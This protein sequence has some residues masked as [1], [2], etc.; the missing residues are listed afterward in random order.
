[1]ITAVKEFIVVLRQSLKDFSNDNGAEWAAAIAYYTLLSIFPLLLASISIGA[2]FVSPEWAYAQASQYLSELFPAGRG[3]L[4]SI[5]RGIMERRQSVSIIS[6]VLLLFAGTRVFGTVTKALN[7][8]FGTGEHY[9]LLKRTTLQLLMLLS[10]GGLFLISITSQ[11]IIGFLIRYIPFL[12]SNSGLLFTTGAEILLGLLLL[13]TFYLTYRYVPNYN[14]DSRAAFIGAMLATLGFLVARPLFVGYVNRFVN[15][16]LIYGPLAVVIIFILWIWV[17]A[18]ILMFCG[19]VTSHYQ[20]IRVQNVS[21]E[22]VETMHI[23]RSPT[24]KDIEGVNLPPKE[25]EISD[26]R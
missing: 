26:P 11:I 20:L 2:M 1:M 23:R 6:I 22:K 10:L 3:E 8:A 25:E 19:E 17:V 5:I 4:A 18:L 16:S 12:Q 21:V 9:S 13:L 14:V 24:K 7:I 15:L